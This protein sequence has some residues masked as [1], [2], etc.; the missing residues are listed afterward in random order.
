MDMQF[1]CSETKH[2]GKPALITLA[3]ET[4][5]DDKSSFKNLWE[6]VQAYTR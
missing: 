6:P 5:F 4:W 2:A 3:K 1:N